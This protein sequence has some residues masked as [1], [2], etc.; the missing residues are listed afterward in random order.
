M[1]KELRAAIR[2]LS[3]M[4]SSGQH[5]A[6]V[7]EECDEL[8]VEVNDV[9]DNNFTVPN[10]KVLSEMADVLNT[11]EIY[12]DSLGMD[13]SELD[14]YRL[15]Q[16][17]KH[18]KP[19]IVDTP[20]FDADGDIT[21]DTLYTIKEW[22]NEKGWSALINFIRDCYNLNYGKIEYYKDEIVFITGG[23]SNNERVL[24]AIESNYLFRGLFWKASYRGGK[25]VF[26][27]P[28]NEKR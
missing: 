22:T 20:E 4:K 2:E 21:E 15:K 27:L 9:I 10:Y 17:K 7:K 6:K 1:T 13:I 24:Q 12:M 18:L 16:V 5:L 11:I 25:T 14:V 8:L 28:E 26:Q 3:Q 23:W 19:K